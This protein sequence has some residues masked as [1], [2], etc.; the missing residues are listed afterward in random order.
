MKTN[1]YIY[2]EWFSSTGH[3]RDGHKPDI[4]A[5]FPIPFRPM[6]EMHIRWWIPIIGKQ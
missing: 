6:S 3:E 1:R 2:G 5:Y 4:V